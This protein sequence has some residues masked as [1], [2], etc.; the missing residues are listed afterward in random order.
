LRTHI[1]HYDVIWS[2]IENTYMTLWR[3]LVVY[4]EHMNDIMTSLVVYWK[5]IKLYNIMTSFGRILRTHEWHDDVT[6]IY[7]AC[8]KGGKI[9]MASSK[10]WFLFRLY[11]ASVCPIKIQINNKTI[12]EFG[13]R[14]ICWI[15]KAWFVFNICLGLRLR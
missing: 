7:A 5:H 3:H 15:I 14:R 12:I 13:S 11:N 9:Q 2:N 8:A 4:W 1:W 10:K 6:L